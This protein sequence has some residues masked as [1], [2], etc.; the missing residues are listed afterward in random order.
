MLPDL[1][2]VVLQPEENDSSDY[3]G[4]EEVHGSSEDSLE[5]SSVSKKQAAKEQRSHKSAVPQLKTAS[6][7]IVVKKKRGKK[8]KTE[9]K[10]EPF[11]IDF[12]SP[13]EEETKVEPTI[14][15]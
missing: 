4:E 9:A 10:T 1:F 5:E 7:Q 14:V 13:V 2:N 11:I 15:F 12:Y 8:V 3:G 6:R